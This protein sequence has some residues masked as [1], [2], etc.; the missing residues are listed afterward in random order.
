MT[1]VSGCGRPEEVAVQRRD[2]FKG[3]AVGAAGLV[4]KPVAPAE[5]APAQ[6]PGRPRIK[7]PTEADEFGYA[8]S[9]G[10]ATTGAA[11]KEGAVRYGSDLMVDVLRKLGFEYVAINPGSAFQGLHESLLNHGG[12]T[13]P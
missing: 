3:A 12:N 4:V 1:R 8:Q 5:A 10:A 2:F 9:R 6:V 11:G 13:A 7:Q